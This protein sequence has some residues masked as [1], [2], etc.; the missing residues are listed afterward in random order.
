LEQIVISKVSEQ[1]EA[2]AAEGGFSL[3]H[4]LERSLDY[5]DWRNPYCEMMEVAENLCEQIMEDM[6]ESFM[7]EMLEPIAIRDAKAAC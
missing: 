4:M 3:E 1:A 7:D 2:T 5:Q 6:M